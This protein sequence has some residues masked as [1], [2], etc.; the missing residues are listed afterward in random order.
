MAG[1]P[2]SAF[3]TLHVTAIIILQGAAISVQNKATRNVTMPGSNASRALGKTQRT[4]PAENGQLQVGSG[5]GNN[6]HAQDDFSED[7]AVY[8]LRIEMIK[9]EILAKLQLDRQPVL[10]EKPNESR[11]AALLANLNLIEEEN[12]ENQLE[13]AEEEYYGKTTKIIVFSEKGR[14]FICVS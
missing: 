9:A 4:I 12:E 7:S 8:K 6:N 1:F 3:I 14:S 10:K 11:I 13:D 2:C 5:L